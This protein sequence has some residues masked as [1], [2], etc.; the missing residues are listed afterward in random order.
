MKRKYGAHAFVWQDRYGD[1]ELLRILD[2]AVK[3]GLSIVEVA[4]GNDI[5][6][7]ADLLGREAAARNLELV[8]SPGGD[9]PMQCDISL[10]DENDRR[11]GREWH[12]RAIDLAAK[13]GAETYAGALYG[14][15]GRVVRGGR[16]RDEVC[17]VADGLH[18]LAA[19][20]DERNVR[21]VL[22]PMSHFRTHVANTPPQINRLIVLS[23][24]PNLWSLLDT[25]HLCTEVGDLARAFGE[26]LPH[27]WG[28][29]ACENTRGAPGTGLLPWQT[30]VNAIV[31]SGWNGYI[32]FESYNSSWRNGDFARERGMFHNVCP[33]AEQFIRQATTFLESCFANTARQQ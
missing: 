1:A 28:I 11:L 31:H 14:H 16:N 6:F 18:A 27:L 5:A 19:Y 30:L 8:I 23:D 26:M 29:H 21:L 3:L 20:A 25:Y 7:S 15:P 32:G 4:V 9:W 24:H 13:C 22:E 17:R 10:E 33:D 2:S 12:Q